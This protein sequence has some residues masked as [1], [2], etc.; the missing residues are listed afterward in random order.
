MTSIFLSQLTAFQVLQL[1]SGMGVAPSSLS[2]SKL[3]SHLRRRKKHAIIFQHSQFF[4]IGISLHLV[5]VY[6]NISVYMSLYARRCPL[7]LLTKLMPLIYSVHPLLSLPSLTDKRTHLQDCH[8]NVSSS[9]RFN[10]K[11]HFILQ[12]VGVCIKL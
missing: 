3:P 7:P 8:F 1:S 11:L 5:Y 10:I 9:L 4:T 12:F 2:H 6:I